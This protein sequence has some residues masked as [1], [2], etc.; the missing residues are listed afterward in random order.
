MLGDRDEWRC[1]LCGGDVPRVFVPD[2]DCAPSRD[3][4]IP[5]SAGGGD[6]PANLR[7]AHRA[8]NA[9]MW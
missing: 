2:S 1:W 4:V 9:R 8:C 3:H 6:D 7:L 5:R